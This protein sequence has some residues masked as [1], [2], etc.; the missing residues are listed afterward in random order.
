MADCTNHKVLQPARDSGIDYQVGD[1]MRLD[2]D[3]LDWYRKN[4]SDKIDLE[5]TNE[6]ASHYALLTG[7]CGRCG[8]EQTKVG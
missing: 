1:V 6:E 5:P 8:A 7:P 3:T 4:A 2:A